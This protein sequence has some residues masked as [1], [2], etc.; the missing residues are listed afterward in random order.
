MA[1]KTVPWKAGRIISSKVERMDFRMVRVRD[2]LTAV[3]IPFPMVL[4]MVSQMVL[5]K[6][7]LMA[8]WMV[9]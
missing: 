9:V 6:G 4:Q 1:L 2:S 8:V 5:L 7:Y 3:A